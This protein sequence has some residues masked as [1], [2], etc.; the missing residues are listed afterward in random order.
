M[1]FSARGRH[2]GL[3]LVSSVVCLQC[4][5]TISRKARFI[6]WASGRTARALLNMEDHGRRLATHKAP[7]DTPRDFPLIEYKI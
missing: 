3:H 6:R 4:A 1:K 7:F 5:V 2:L